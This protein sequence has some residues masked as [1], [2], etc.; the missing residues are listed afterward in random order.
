MKPPK[1]IIERARRNAASPVRWKNGRKTSAYPA[2]WMAHVGAST[3]CGT[4][5]ANTLIR[6]LLY[7]WRGTMDYTV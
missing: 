5:Q 6:T 3:P 4:M 7:S 1:E 2:S